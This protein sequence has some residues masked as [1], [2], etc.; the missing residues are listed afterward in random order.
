MLPGRMCY[1][2]R[3]R[4][5]NAN[6]YANHDEGDCVRLDP[7]R[8]RGIGGKRRAKAVSFFPA[9]MIWERVVLH[10]RGARSY[11][12]KSGAGQRPT[13]TEARPI[14]VSARQKVDGID[15]VTGRNEGTI[16]YCGVRSRS[17]RTGTSDPNGPAVRSE[18]S[19]SATYTPA[20][21]A[22]RLIS[23]G[24]VSI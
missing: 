17:T 19:R 24:G 9:P 6:R 2:P 22:P 10:R 4:R 18:G 3:P 1:S 8:D 12:A 7:R 13:R 16:R 20:N 5:C 14:T 23:L 11:T 21:T 15:M